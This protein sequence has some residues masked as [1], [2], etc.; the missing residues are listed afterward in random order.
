MGLRCLAVRVNN[1]TV[2]HLI[3][4]GY[5]SLESIEATPAVANIAAAS[6][7]FEVVGP[8]APWAKTA[9]QSARPQAHAAIENVPR[10]QPFVFNRILP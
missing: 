9:G 6:L 4:T 8:T 2:R 5:L 1:R 3:S 10:S 7:F